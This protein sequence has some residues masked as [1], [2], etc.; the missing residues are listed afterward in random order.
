MKKEYPRLLI[1]D[2]YNLLLKSNINLINSTLEIKR[3]FLTSLIYKNLLKFA[4]EGNIVFDGKGGYREKISPNLTIS[5]AS[6]ADKEIEKLCYKNA[7]IRKI[8]LITSDNAILNT[9]LSKIHRHYRS[10]E[11]L[12]LLDK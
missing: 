1:V 7:K 12:T 4:D 2:G 10:G 6:N 9:V 8:I 3:E 11:F 5:F